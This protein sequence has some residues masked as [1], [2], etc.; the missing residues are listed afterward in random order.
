MDSSDILHN[1]I[2]GRE[3]ERFKSKP[4]GN[5]LEV[6]SLCTP[7][8]AQIKIHNSQ[9][10]TINKVNPHQKSD[11]TGLTATNKPVI[12]GRIAIEIDLTIYCILDMVV[13]KIINKH[14]LS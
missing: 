7:M 5:N 6:F 10:L 12:R 8:R 13:Q 14:L 3:N 1:A 9:T 2:K 4:S 11:Q